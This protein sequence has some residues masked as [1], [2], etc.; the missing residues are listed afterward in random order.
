VLARLAPLV[1]GKPGKLFLKIG[2]NDLSF[3]DPPEQVAANVAEILARFRRGSPD[4]Q[5]YVQSVLPRQAKWADRVEALNAE[6]ERVAFQAGATWIDLYPHFLDESDRSIRDDLANDELHLLGDGYLLWRSRIE[7]H[8]RG[9]S[10]RVAS[11][12]PELEQ[13]DLAA[14][15]ELVA[16]DSQRFRLVN[17]WAT[18]CAPCLAE[19]PLLVGLSE[20]YRELE[21]VTLS[22][23]ALEQRA[24]ALAFLKEI[25]ASTRNWIIRP[26]DMH[27]LLQTLD[28]EW[29]GP[30]P[31]TL[32]V[33]PGGSVAY[34]KQGAFDPAELE[35]VI[36]EQ[37]RGQAS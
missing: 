22:I 31:Y 10:E 1:R 15:A 2:T 32:L 8:V 5:L 30:L 23:D 19:L 17:V 33:A 4:T 14:V 7:G 20:R 21:V 16:N 9:A 29:G 36:V 34:R 24:D 12:A 25:G 37:L 27:Q 11:S 13:V 18:W 28:P 26:V 35:A 6:L 3:G